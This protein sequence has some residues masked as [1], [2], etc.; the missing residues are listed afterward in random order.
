MARRKKK[1][2]LIER[3]TSLWKTRTKK[4]AQARKQTLITAVKAAAVMCLLVAGGAFLR[5][6]EGYVRTVQPS[7]EGTLVLRDV[8]KWANY[9]LKRRVLELAGGS[10]LPVREETASVVARNLAPMSWLDDVEVEVTHDKVFVKARW[11]KPVAIVKRGPSRFYVD[12]DLVVLDYMPMAH[13]P[14]VEVT[15][16][17][18]GLPPSPGAVFDRDDLAAAVKLIDLLSRVD[19]E[20]D[21]RNRLLEQIA[22]IDV[23]N[24]KGRKNDSKP[25]L[26]LRSKEGT[27][28]L[29]GAEIGEWTKHFEATDEDK[30]A[31]LYGYYK[32]FGSLS[33]G[34]KY[35]N[36]Y[37]DLNKV[38]L[39]VDKYH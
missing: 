35:I 37:E 13:L 15:G 29:W 7:P 9:D 21:P 6:A 28:I 4:E 22:S 11:R 32:E 3:I 17:K 2:S 10:R 27:Q 30:L 23:D 31:K 14:I 39:P 19:A 12:L 8:P 20:L 16:V 24:Y 5:Y 34:A 1:V 36:L 33:A 38:R 26:V 18:T 25:H